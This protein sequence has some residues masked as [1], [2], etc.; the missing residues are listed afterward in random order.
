[1]ARLPAAPP[2]RFRQPRGARRPV[3][4]LASL[5]THVAPR[6]DEW[7]L[8][9]LLERAVT[10]VRTSLDAR[11]NGRVEWGFTA[12]RPALR[13][14]TQA[15]LRFDRMGR[16]AEA[17]DLFDWVLR[18]N[19]DDNQGHRGWLVNHYLKA[20]DDERAL[21]VSP[22][23][24]EDALVDTSFGR[25]LALWRLGRLEEAKKQLSAAARETPR[26]ARAL[27]ARK[28]R[29]PEISPYGITVGGEDEAWIY[30]EQMRE[31]WR[32][33]PAAL[34]FL[35]GL[36]IPGPT[37]STYPRPRRDR[38]RRKERAPDPEEF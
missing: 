34:E 35:A 10:I 7:L 23:L 3:L 18:L 6:V 22:H 4:V 29:Q 11:P 17:A 1:M 20:G 2:R 9:P 16:A 19:P 38:P 37:R 28:M 26:T 12:N 25:A 36:D 5:V 24:E 30:R 31:T 21:A 13:L 14:L 32:A 15:G 8:A 33:T 27:V